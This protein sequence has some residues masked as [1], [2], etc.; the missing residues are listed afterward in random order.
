MFTQQQRPSLASAYTLT[1]TRR[2]LLHKPPPLRPSNSN[3]PNATAATATAQQQSYAPAARPTTRQPHQ[4]SQDDVDAAAPA[5][6]T[7]SRK[8]PYHIAAPSL[9]YA[10]GAPTLPRAGTASQGSSPSRSA[11]AP[12]NTTVNIATAFAQAAATGSVSPLRNPFAATETTTRK[13]GGKNNKN[14]DNGNEEEGA[15]R[16]RVSGPITRRRSRA[17]SSTNDN[18][19]DESALATDDVANILDSDDEEQFYTPAPIAARKKTS[20]STAT[21]SG[22]LWSLRWPRGQLHSVEVDEEEQGEHEKE[23]QDTWQGNRS[24]PLGGGGAQKPRRETDEYLEYQDDGHERR[25]VQ[26]SGLSS[27]YFFRTRDRTPGGRLKL[28]YSL[29]DESPPSALDALGEDGWNANDREELDDD[30]VRT[31]DEGEDMYEEEERI[32]QEMLIT[33]DDGGHGDNRIHDLE[34]E[35]ERSVRQKRGHTPSLFERFGIGV[36]SVPPAPARHT[37]PS[38]VH[39][40]APAAVSLHSTGAPTVAHL[41]PGPGSYSP[42]ASDPTGDSYSGEY[43][44]TDDMSDSGSG[45][46]DFA[47]RPPVWQPLQRLLSRMVSS[48]GSG[49]GWVL[50]KFLFA[51]FICIWVAKEVALWIVNGLAHAAAE[52]VRA[53]KTYVVNPAGVV[54]QMAHIGWGKFGSFLVEATGLVLM[55][56]IEMVT[57]TV[58]TGRK[59]VPLT[60]MWFRS[61]L[62]RLVKESATWGPI[63]LMALSVVIVIG[64]GVRYVNVGKVSS[65]AVR[66]I[67]RPL[68]P[69]PIAE[70]PFWDSILRSIVGWRSR[71]QTTA[72]VAPS[73]P[74]ETFEDI[75]ARIVKM[76]LNL[77]TSDVNSEELREQFIELQ[78]QVE[79]L[80][81]QE[82]DVEL[83]KS[84]YNTLRRDV[85][86][87]KKHVDPDALAKVIHSTVEGMLPEF[88]M[89]PMNS[90]TGKIEFHPEFWKHLKSLFMSKSE[91][92]ADIKKMTEGVEHERKEREAIVLALEREKKEREMK[93]KKFMGQLEEERAERLT[94]GAMFTTKEMFDTVWKELKAYMKKDEVAAVLEI[95]KNEVEADITLAVD[96]L[97][98]ERQRD[99]RIFL[100]KEQ[101]E[102]IVNGRVDAIRREITDGTAITKVIPPMWGDFVRENQADMNEFVQQHVERRIGEITRSNS[103]V[104]LSKNDFLDILNTELH[105][106][107]EEMLENI[108]KQRKVHVDIDMNDDSVSAIQQLI[109]S[110]LQKYSE[111]VLAMPDYALLSSGARVI[112][113]LTSKNYEVYPRSLQGRFTALISGVGITRGAPPQV[114][115]HP[116]NHVGQCWSFHGSVGELG[117]QLSRPVIVT[118]IT[119]EHVSRHV[120]H[121]LKSAPR[122]IEVWAVDWRE[123]TPAGIEDGE[124]VRDHSPFLITSFSYELN[125]ENP[126]QTF[127]VSKKHLRSDRTVQVVIVKVKSNWGH[128]DFTC[129]YRVRVHGRSVEV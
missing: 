90:K 128:P 5:P 57:M 103:G 91:F 73:F 17:R 10:Y 31:D 117:I 61:A 22:R 27:R 115:L 71:P 32:F 86:T 110:A 21:V 46:F 66:A 126:I 42:D 113:T 60:W 14:N 123:V 78:R 29:S 109:D 76:E 96:R 125:D 20:G 56:F 104:I 37:V 68:D 49:F 43:T 99:E 120:A 98:N 82:K 72:Y 38:E 112:P 122:E 116:D 59:L 8:A 63:A 74:P 64:M 24:V 50:S 45:P 35:Q 106:L 87:L 127:P 77:R 107:K 93:E 48:S 79:A 28:E 65:E 70:V 97:S 6:R 44:D 2:H 80:S 13:R 55:W 88:L 95:L 3:A 52:G 102:A 100:K 7:A 36:K 1:P 26:E 53:V 94:W 92:V 119:V 34:E 58:M 23:N 41:A 9:S 39:R 54:G 121:D 40:P 15:A 75:G 69:S 4:L 83:I 51:L 118:D 111:D 89:M 30:M 11:G 62:R 108:A 19:G 16:S 129:L 105:R 33:D 84:E 67:P 18:N 85:D 114:A 47:D 81:R 25:E 12:L 101:V 124:P